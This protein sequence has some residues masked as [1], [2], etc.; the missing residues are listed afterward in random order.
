MSSGN[1]EVINRLFIL[2]YDSGKGINFQYHQYSQAGVFIFMTLS[3]FY[4][5]KRET[6]F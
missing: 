1:A 4:Y 2:K 3:L 6:V 5:L